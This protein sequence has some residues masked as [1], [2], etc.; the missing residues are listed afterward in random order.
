VAPRV[1]ARG[2]GS[3]S[4]YSFVFIAMCRAAGIPARYVGSVVVRRDASSWDDV[5]HR[6]V[7]IYLP[8]FGWLPVD[9]SRGDKKSEAKRGD[10]FHHL[11]PDFVVTT[12]SGGGSRYLGWT[13]NYDARWTCL[14]RCLA[15][16]DA[17]AEWAPKGP[18]RVKARRRRP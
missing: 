9:P 7:E 2:S 16:P 18:R 1:L 6:W 8:G 12:Q 10:A 17:I 14:G 15:R 13:Y 11:T 5:Y 4:E 3:C